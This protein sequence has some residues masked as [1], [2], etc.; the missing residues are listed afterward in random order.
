MIRINGDRLLSD[1]RKLAGFGA[2]KTGVDRI[3]LSAPDLEARR[4]LMARMKEVGLQPHMDEVANVYGRHPTAKQ[5]LLI[6]SHTDCCGLPHGL[7]RSCRAWEA[8]TRSGIL[9]VSTSGRAPQTW[10]RARA[11][12]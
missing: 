12:W 8:P 9:A 7:R 5:A 1:L 4:W 6:G 10:C 3:A 11:R 2:F